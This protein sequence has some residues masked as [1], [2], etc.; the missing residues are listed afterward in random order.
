[1]WFTA[2]NLLLGIQAL[3]LILIMIHL[4]EVLNELAS[5]SE[6]TSHFTRDVTIFSLGEGLN[7]YVQADSQPSVGI[8]LL[9][10]Y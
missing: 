7:V 3:C 4:F 10:D 9:S 1:M 8:D 5:V 2:A 6:L